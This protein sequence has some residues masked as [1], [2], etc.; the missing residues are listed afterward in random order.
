MEIIIKCICG[1]ELHI[2]DVIGSGITSTIRVEPCS[3]CIAKAWG[4]GYKLGYEK[5]MICILEENMEHETIK[6]EKGEMKN[7]IKRRQIEKCSNMI[8]LY[9]IKL[10]YACFEI[11]VTGDTITKAAP[12]GE[13]MVGKG[14]GGVEQ[15]VRGRGGRIKRVN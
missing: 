15:W 13:W 9:Q 12:I 14:I 1:K 4:K 5:G 2:T 7:P 8:T 6:R 11:E 10:S 3:D